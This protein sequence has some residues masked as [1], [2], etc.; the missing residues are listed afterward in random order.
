[1]RK[2]KLLSLLCFYY[3]FGNS[4]EFRHYDFLG[5]GHDN[6]VRVTASSSAPQR[7]PQ[8]TIDGFSI[9]NTEQLK[10]ASRFL[11]QA[12]FGAD[13]TTIEMVAAMGY[14]AW[15]EEQ[16]SLP[17]IPILEEMIHHGSLYGKTFG[18]PR[19]RI[20]QK[21][22][23]SAWITTN[24]NAPDLL[25]QRLAYNWSQVM[26]INNSSDFYKGA[27]QLMATYYDSLAVNAFENYHKLLT[28]VTLSPA[29]GGFLSH[30]NNPK[31]DLEKNIHPDENYAREVMQLFS[32]GL[33]ELNA[34]GTRKYNEAGQYIPTYS[35]ADI[36]E[37][38]QVFTGLG[39]GRSDG[40]FGEKL[41]DVDDYV[42]DKLGLPM[43]MY[44]E[45]HDQSEKH[46]LNG[47]VLPANQDGMTDVEQTLAHLSEHPNTAPFISK[48]LIKMMTTSNPSP[49]YVRDVAEIFDP[50]APNNLQDLI[51]AILLHPEAR[52]CV[53]TENY[54]FGKLREPLVRVLNFIRAF[55]ILA[56]PLNDYVYH[57]P[58]FHAITGQSPLSAPSV[59]NFYLPEYSPPGPINDN[60]LVAPEFEILDANSSIRI[61]NDIDRRVL[62]GKHFFDLCPWEVEDDEEEIIEEGEEI[63]EEKEPHPIIYQYPASLAE[64][65]EQLV[66]YLDILLA[67][68][69]LTDPT[70]ETIIEA[71]SQLDTREA[72]VQ[73]AIY[74]TLI[75]PDYSILK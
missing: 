2:I 56:N 44:N 64:E 35:N 28:D 5:A 18:N 20:H 4:Q 70:K 43:R 16:F 30:F 53:P 74:L 47:V 52:T 23:R 72:R 50:F 61:V 54:T 29:M 45:Q 67:N 63:V 49:A 41:T 6:E 46:L 22:F 58:C 69:L 26:V 36:K 39:D 13:F 42:I 3:L 21:F 27:S 11:A 10:A 60:Y 75:S 55:P 66:D 68:G 32:I 59:F 62:D 1:M 15:L 71:I 51:K 14:E 9:Q 65:P 37:F 38:A 48:A 34:D 12:T 24:L 57:M 17:Y 25:R 8:Q 7:Y 31:E 40:E 19:E 33:W 73:M